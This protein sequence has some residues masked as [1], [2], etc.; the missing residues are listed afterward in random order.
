MSRGCSHA[1]A[2]W[3]VFL[4]ADDRLRSGAVSELLAGVD[5]DGVA[6]YGDYDRSTRTERSSGADD[7]SAASANPAE[8]SSDGFS[9]ETFWSTAA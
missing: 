5:D 2:S 9:L 7:S 1:A 6:V 3:V 4:D 8:T